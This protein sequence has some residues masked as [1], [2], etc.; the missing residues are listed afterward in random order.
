[1]VLA[2]VGLLVAAG[3]TARAEEKRVFSF[4]VSPLYLLPSFPYAD[5]Y[6]FGVGG[7][8]S[9]SLQALNNTPIYIAGDAGYQMT[10]LSNE[11]MVIGIT[12]LGV[13]VG[14]ELALLP[15]L[16]FTPWLKGGYFWADLMDGGKGQN[17]WASATL[18][19]D[20]LLFGGFS[21]GLEA[22]YRHFFGL[23][24]D[25]A[26]SL[27]AAYS[28]GRTPIPKSPRTEIRPAQPKPQP[29]EGSGTEIISLS[30][31]PVYPVFFSYYDDFPLGRAVLHNF[32]N[33]PAEEIAVALF[34]KQYMDNPKEVRITE[35]LAPGEERTIDLYGLFT[36][37]ILEVTEGKKVSA[38]IT[39]E[40]SQLGKQHTAERVETVEVKG[41]NAL[42]WDDDRKAAAF[43]T[44]KDPAVMKV[45]KNVAGFLQQGSSG[46][47]DRNLQLG[48][49][50]H[51]TLDHMGLSYAVDPTTP[52]EQLSAREQA[53]DFLQ[54]P[55][56]TLEFRGGD[57][58]D[59]A[60]LYAALLESLGVETAFITIPG[61]IYCAFALEIGPEE[62]RAVF[63]RS[64]NLIMREG[65][66]WVPVEITLRGRGFVAAWQEGAKEWREYSSAGKAALLPVHEGW[67]V[68]KPVG[69]PG[70]ASLNVPA[71]DAVLG[72]YQKEMGKLIQRELAVRVAELSDKIETSGGA[73]RWRNALGVLYARYGLHEKAREQFDKALAQRSSYYP[74]LLNLGNLSYLRERYE[75]A[76]GYYLKA[77]DHAPDSA[78]VLLAVARVYHE[79]ENYYG[80]AKAYR[81]LQ[82]KNPQIASRYSYLALRGD[83]AGRAAEASGVIGEV[84]WADQE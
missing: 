12:S 17:P 74:A 65:R 54:F 76:L 40:Y 45:A 48:V 77:R 14:W 82:E 70:S 3:G 58:D 7:E 25:T 53:I 68:F 61:H 37:E 72:S 5:Y 22:S 30:I 84:I 35:P 34:I 26:L 46:S 50:L 41:R 62:A 83:E 47:L 78:T 59:L 66:V 9:A 18:S 55:R 2:S 6:N 27:S 32:E 36:S 39:M 23:Y 80:A 75:E 15:R 8:F 69:L 71:R 42:T 21:L 81:R 19:L 16:I 10:Q 56:Q 29:L 24:A 28:F 73:P 20:Y 49:A 4:S 44:A 67:T 57:C 33:S 38:R 52:Y 60:V 11:Y 79:L 51:E 43:V 31:D 64:D 1:M 63:D 13:G